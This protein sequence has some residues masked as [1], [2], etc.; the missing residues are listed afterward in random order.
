MNI[1]WDENICT[2]SGTCV[3]TLPNVFKIENGEFV[4]DTLRENEA[5][6]I[7]TVNKCPPGALRIAQ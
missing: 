4:I 6:I 1:E 5:A 7:D 2:H 3:Q